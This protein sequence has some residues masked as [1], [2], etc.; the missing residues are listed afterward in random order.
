M[1]RLHWLIPAALTVV[2]N[3]AIVSQRLAH[4]ADFR[5]YGA[6][7]CFEENLGIWTVIEGDVKPGECKDFNGNKVFSLTNV[8]ISEGCTRGLLVQTRRNR[9]PLT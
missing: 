8:D 1:G 4:L 9:S 6:T 5:I 3:G 2:A 7:E